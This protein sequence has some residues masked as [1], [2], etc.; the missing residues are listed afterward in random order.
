M[1]QLLERYHHT[2]E[3]FTRVRVLV[4]DWLAEDTLVDFGKRIEELE[5]RISMMNQ[6]KNGVDMSD[7]EKLLA[8]YMKKSD[9]DSWLKR[10]EKVEK[11]A[12]KAK[13]NSKKAL[14]KIGKW[15][16]QWKQMQRDIEDL[17]ALSNRKVD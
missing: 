14:K 3:D 11:K 15:K 13:D 12:K 6:G 10:L 1:S 5:K 2:L 16:P 4:S 7:I 9:M 8:D 17:K